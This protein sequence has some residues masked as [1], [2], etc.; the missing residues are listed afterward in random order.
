MHSGTSRNDEIYDEEFEKK[1]KTEYGYTIAE[2]EQIIDSA[3]TKEQP[4]FDNAYLRNKIDLRQKRLNVFSFPSKPVKHPADFVKT[5]YKEYRNA[6]RVKFEAR[7]QQVRV[8]EK[9]G[10]VRDYIKNTYY[11]SDSG[12]YVCQ[13]CGK[14]IDDTEIVQI[15]ENPRRELKAMHLCLCSEC[16]K[17]YRKKRKDSDKLNN[18]LYELRKAEYTLEEPI[19]V[20]IDNIEVHFN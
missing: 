2:F 19:P 6:P 11:D 16:A 10:I 20:T 9:P 5:V 14:P 3:S 4:Y 15:E 18:F 17:E 12:F 1:L 8:S 7:V 13:I